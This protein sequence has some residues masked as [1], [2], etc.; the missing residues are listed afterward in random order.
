[1]GPVAGIGADLSGGSASAT[2]ALLASGLPGLPGTLL[3]HGTGAGER[4]L[5]VT[6]NDLTTRGNEDELERARVIAANPRLHHVVVAAGEEALPYASLGAGALTDEPA[7]SLVLAE[8]HRRRLSAGSADHL[9]GH[10]AR[11]VLDAHPARLADLL[12]DRRRRHLLRPVAALTKAEGPT[13][14]SLFVPLTVYRAA[15]R[16]ARTSYRTGLESAAGLLPDANR[17]A[18]DLATPA[19]ASLAA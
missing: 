17:H 2:L 14:H 19:D 5:A 8:R 6:F 10:G 16:L 3:G 1:G 15:R 18:P 7:P 12:M 13:A 11:Q 4:L 9:V